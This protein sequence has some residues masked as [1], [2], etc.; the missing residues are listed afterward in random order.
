MLRMPNCG[1]DAFFIKIET[2]EFR[3]KWRKILF[4]GFS[5][6]KSLKDTKTPMFA[7]NL[8]INIKILDFRKKN[9]FSSILHKF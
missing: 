9:S 5:Q 4:W 8:G 6:L 1:W 3:I 7:K 2:I